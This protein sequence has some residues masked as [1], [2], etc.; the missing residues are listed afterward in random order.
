MS[1]RV[2]KVLKNNV[3]SLDGQKVNYNIS[4]SHR[5]SLV[6]KIEPGKTLEVCAPARATQNG[7]A[8]FLKE[9]SNWILKNLDRYKDYNVL[10]MPKSFCNGQILYFLGDPYKL[11]IKRDLANSVMLSKSEMIVSSP[12]NDESKIKNIV[13]KWYKEQV[14]KIFSESMEEC[15]KKVADIGIRKAKPIKYRK[16]DKRWGTCTGD[17]QIILNNSLIFVDREFIDYIILHE[18]CHFKEK[19]HGPK[20]YELMHKIC[21]NYII[22][23]KNLNHLIIENFL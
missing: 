18:F 11:I 14:K 10:E 16:M 8:S 9:K 3:I 17:N 1:L 13:I 7:I 22:L 6:I 12:Y 2:T 23:R 5:K 15:L 19:N 20:F 21:P 4:F